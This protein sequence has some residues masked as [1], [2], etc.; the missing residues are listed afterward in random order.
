MNEIELEEFMQTMPGEDEIAPQTARHKQY[1]IRDAKFALQ[2]QPPREAIVEGLIFRGDVVLPFGEA[3]S[4]KT[5]AFGCSL[6]VCVACGKPWLDYKTTKNKVLIIEEEMDELNFSARLGDAIRGELADGSIELEFIC[7]AG[8]RLDDYADTV[9]LQA[10]I[11][12]RGAGLVVIDALSEVMIGDENSK[13]DTMPI[14]AALRRI[15]AA[16]TAAIII[17]HHS[18][19][20]GGYRGSSHIKGAIDLMIEVKSEDGSRFINFRTEKTR[21]IK[22]QSWAAEAVWTEDQ[23]YVTA[24]E[25][26]EKTFFSKSEDYVMRYLK[27]NPNASIEDIGDHADA[28]SAQAAQRAVYNLTARKLVVR[29]DGGGRG[30]KALYALAPQ[31]SEL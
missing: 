26:R 14:F 10:L 15:A 2:P 7:L 29:T 31:T 4:K 12:E 11:E 3:G 19:K 16:T 25:K 24:A 20:Q 9:V 23:F 8:F 18:N 1:I 27:E 5:Y 13:Q 30:R 6:A 28:C 17:I 22:H 21:Y